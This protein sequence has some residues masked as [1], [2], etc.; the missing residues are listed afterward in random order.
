MDI[1]PFNP[2]R[3]AL[4]VGNRHYL[5]DLTLAEDGTGLA[6][7]SE[8]DAKGQVAYLCTVVNFQPKGLW[9]FPSGL[10]ADGRPTPVE[11]ARVYLARK[12]GLAMA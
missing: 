11:A 2:N 5:L 8:V 6:R 10:S 7:L 4:Q 3:K 1:I 9:T 12:L